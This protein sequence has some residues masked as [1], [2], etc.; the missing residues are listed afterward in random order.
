[1]RSALGHERPKPIAQIESALPQSPDIGQRGRLVS[2]V[3]EAE[4]QANSFRAYIV[5]VANIGPARSMSL[6]VHH[7]VDLYGAG[8]LKNHFA[9]VSRVLEK[10]LLD[11]FESNWNRDSLTVRRNR[12]RDWCLNR[13]FISKL[14][15]DRKELVGCLSFVPNF[16]RASRRDLAF[17][18]LLHH[19]VHD[20][21]IA[22]LDLVCMDCR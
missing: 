16:D 21:K 11:V 19:G 3:P 9:G 2:S 1:M 5:L 13:H 22:D 7:E 4:M 10:R 8:L 14:R 6:R 12:Y 18:G 17:L 20:N 15:A